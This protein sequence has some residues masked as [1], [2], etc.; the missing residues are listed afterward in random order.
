MNVQIPLELCQKAPNRDVS[1]PTS[2]LYHA[3]GVRGNHYV[4]EVSVRDNHSRE[5]L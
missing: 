1:M 4:T 5:V 3:F 2:L